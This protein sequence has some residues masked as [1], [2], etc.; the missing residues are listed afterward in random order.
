MGGHET[1]KSVCLLWGLPHGKMQSQVT[2]CGFSAFSLRQLHVF[3][4]FSARHELAKL[5]LALRL[6]RCF[7]TPVPFPGWSCHW[8]MGIMGGF[9]D[10]KLWNPRNCTDTTRCFFWD[11][12]WGYD[13]IYG[14]YMGGIH[15]VGRRCYSLVISDAC[16]VFLQSLW[17]HHEVVQLWRKLNWFAPK[18][19]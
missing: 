13:G 6:M 10:L 14:L 15:E 4:P 17:L 8:A 9:S 2:L 7:T 5:G 12:I 18:C 16:K 11:L 3:Q 19:L 1:S